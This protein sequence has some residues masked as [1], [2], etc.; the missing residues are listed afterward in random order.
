MYLDGMNAFNLYLKDDFDSFKDEFDD[1]EIDDT[2]NAFKPLEAAKEPAKSPFSSEKESPKAE[3][4]KK[5]ESDIP[6]FPKNGGTFDRKPSDDVSKGPDKSNTPV[7]GSEKGNTRPAASQK[8]DEKLFNSGK[9]LDYATSEHDKNQ[10]P[11]ANPSR[12]AAKQTRSLRS[13]HTEQYLPV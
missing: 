4:E 5:A 1:F 9:D 7:F 11:F 13:R 2:F 10:S 6:A 3:P 8:K 12:P